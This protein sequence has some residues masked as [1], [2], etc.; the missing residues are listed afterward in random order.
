LSCGMRCNFEEPIDGFVEVGDA[1]EV[2]SFDQATFG[3]I[4]P[5]MVFTPY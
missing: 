5:A 3:I 4:G 1:F 2:R